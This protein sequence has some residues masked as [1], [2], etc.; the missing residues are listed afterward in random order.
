M[1][2]NVLEAVEEYHVYVEEDVEADDTNQ[3]DA[4]DHMGKAAEIPDDVEKH[5]ELKTNDVESYLVDYVLVPNL[6]VP[7]LVFLW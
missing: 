3:K 7:P 2:L 1:L 6:F 5:Y 4:I